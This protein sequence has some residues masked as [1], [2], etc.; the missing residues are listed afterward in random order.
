MTPNAIAADKAQIVRFQNEVSY[1][2][3]MYPSEDEVRDDAELLNSKEG[4]LII[5]W[6]W[7]S[8]L[9]LEGD[10]PFYI[11]SRVNQAVWENVAKLSP[12]IGAE[13]GTAAVEYALKRR[14]Q[15]QREIIASRFDRIIKWTAE[16]VGCSI[17]DLRTHLKWSVP[18]TDQDLHRL[19]TGYTPFAFPVIVR[20]CSALQLE[21][22]DAGFQIDPAGL[23]HRIERSVVASSISSQ[24]QY[25]TVDNLESI[26]K[27]LP[28]GSADAGRAQDLDIYHAP[29]P[30]GRYWS[31]YTVLAADERVAPDYTLAEIDRFL[32]EAGAKRLPASATA[33]RS[34]W[35]GSGTK[36]EG[37]PQVSAWWAAGYRIRKVATYPSSGQIKAV[38]F[39]ALP[40][41]SEWLSNPNRTV[42]REYRVRGSEK[43]WIYPKLDGAIAGLT[44]LAGAI[45]MVAK[46][47]DVEGLAAALTPLAKATEMVAKEVDVEGLAAALTPLARATEMP[48]KEVDLQGFKAGPTGMTAALQRITELNLSRAKLEANVPD[49]PDVHRLVRFLSEVGEA[50]RSQIEGHIKETQNMAVDPAWMKNLLTKARRQGWTVNNGT[51]NQPRWAVKRSAQR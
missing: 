49:D 1:L 14:L 31:L 51:R 20:L 9:Y 33:D 13:N 25:L 41:R 27:K 46:E 7:P 50:S 36:P 22:V 45:E 8:P 10:D 38:G 17:E 11:A 43:V 15:R 24:L 47:L 19:L 4:L 34:W 42:Q 2:D 32:V 5:A 3:R 44:V 29:Q 23:L 16:A 30:G 37:R 28:R 6:L 39:A 48:T 18:L 26:A 12:G 21:F 35:S 40:G